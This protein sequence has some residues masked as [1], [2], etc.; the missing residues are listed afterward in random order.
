MKQKYL[1][2][3]KPNYEIDE[4][5]LEKIYKVASNEIKKVVLT[6]I[7]YKIDLVKKVNLE[8]L[9]SK[10]K[11]I[12]Q[13]DKELW[14]KEFEKEKKTVL[15]LQIENHPLVETKAATQEEIS[16]IIDSHKLLSAIVA[17]NVSE[18]QK[19]LFEVAR[20]L[21]PNDS[22]KGIIELGEIHHSKVSII[23]NHNI[24]ELLKN[25]YITFSYIQS[26]ESNILN[27]LNALD[28]RAIEELVKIGVTISKLLAMKP[29]QQ[30]VF[31]ENALN[32]KNLVT[33]DG[34]DIEILLAMKP[35]QLEWF[36]NDPNKVKI[37]LDLGIDPKIFLDMELDKQKLVFKNICYIKILVE[38]VNV[39][40][41]KFIDMELEKQEFVFENIWNNED[42]N[43]YGPTSN[44]DVQLSLLG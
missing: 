18:N 19:K 13:K 39:N 22:N 23:L 6:K 32:I 1:D 36:S 20:K 5:E 26:V 21:Y 16:L 24:L 3:V 44:D 17:Y 14:K 2:Y 15:K 30:K 29:A 33:K 10:Y 37:L 27:T 8:E 40:F 38:N 42:I 7:D 41:N 11:N 4:T 25:K 9:E 43:N 34:I 28:F 35:A 31:I 12:S